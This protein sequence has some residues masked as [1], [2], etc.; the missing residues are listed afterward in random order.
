MVNIDTSYFYLYIC[1]Q[2]ILNLVINQTLYLFSQ[3]NLRA[4]G[5]IKTRNFK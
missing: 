4:E 2:E 3:K 5:W 1:S